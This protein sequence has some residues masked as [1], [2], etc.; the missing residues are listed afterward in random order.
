MYLYEGTGADVK[1]L[2]LFLLF[3]FRHFRIKKIIIGIFLDM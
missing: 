2:P 3:F 1:H